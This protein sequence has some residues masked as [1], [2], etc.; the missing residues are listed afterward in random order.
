MREGWKEG[1]LEGGRERGS[2]R[3]REESRGG[4]KEGG[5][6]EGE[7]GHQIFLKHGLDKGAMVAK[8][9]EDDCSLTPHIMSD[10][11]MNSLFPNA[12]RHVSL[13][14]S[15]RRNNLSVSLPP[16]VLTLYQSLSLSLSLCYVCVRTCLC[17][18]VCVC[19]CV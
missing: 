15:L 11:S 19:A 2:E 18:C 16:C 17:V 13:S 8:A 4:G 7:G 5:G 1:G 12:P 10:S 14:P 9:E 3:G 6:G